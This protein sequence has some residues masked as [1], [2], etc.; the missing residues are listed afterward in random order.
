MRESAQH[1]MII[2]CHSRIHV[3]LLD[4]LGASLY[5]PG[6]I[7]FSLSEPSTEIEFSGEGSKHDFGSLDSRAVRDVRQL[8]SRLEAISISRPYRVICRK[9]PPANRGFGSKTALLSAIAFGYRAFHHLEFDDD[10]TQLLTGRGGTSGIGFHSFRHGGLIWDGGRPNDGNPI[11]PSSTTYPTRPP[12]LL[13]RWDAPDYG[14][15]LVMP[16]VQHLTHDEEIAFIAKNRS[17]EPHELGQLNSYVFGGFVPAFLTRDIER[18]RDS[19]AGINRTAFKRREVGIYGEVVS[20]IM[21]EIDRLFGMPCGMSSL[22]P[23]LFCLYQP[24]EIDIETT[25]HKIRQIDGVGHVSVSYISNRGYSIEAL[26][27][28]V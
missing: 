28:P 6:G 11:K 18:L 12:L 24:S 8:L 3:T 21:A 25:L 22:G 16:R 13:S 9:L 15:L 14:V 19:L 17:I 10:Q 4:T 26:D 2:R 20:T 7:G 1:Q 23:L 27:E 5:I